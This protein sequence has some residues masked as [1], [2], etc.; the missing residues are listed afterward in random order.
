MGLEFVR[1]NLIMRVD[2]DIFEVWTPSYDS[3]RIPL[4]WLLVRAHSFP[5]K[6]R[7]LV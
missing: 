4:A 3:K 7:L 6:N 5:K 1:N 2:G